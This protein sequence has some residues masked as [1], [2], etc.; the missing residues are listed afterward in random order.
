MLFSLTQLI[1]LIPQIRRVLK[2][3]NLRRLL[4]FG[5]QA[6]DFRLF[7]DSRHFGY[8]LFVF[9]LLPYLYYI[10]YILNDGLR[11]DAMLCVIAALNIAAA[12]W[13]ADSPLNRVGHGIGVH[14]D[15]ALCVSGGSAYRLH[16]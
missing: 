4:H 13:L 12:L 11:R 15:L 14:N 2:L 9:D 16:K 6:L 1:Y 7:F 3:K 5:G 8:R 10:A